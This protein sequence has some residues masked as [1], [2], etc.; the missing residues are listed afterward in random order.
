MNSKDESPSIAHCDYTHVE[1]STNR[2]IIPK[3][4][5]ERVEMYREALE[6]YPDDN[7]IDKEAERKLRRKLDRRILPLLGICYFFYA[8]KQIFAQMIIEKKFC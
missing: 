6:Q 7:S 1:E 8:S 5:Q 4:N 2:A 3:F